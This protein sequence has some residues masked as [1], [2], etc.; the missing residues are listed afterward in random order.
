MALFIESMLVP[1]NNR[2][3]SSSKVLPHSTKYY[4]ELN[5]KAVDCDE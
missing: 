3:Y 1:K 4:H 2:K 5:I